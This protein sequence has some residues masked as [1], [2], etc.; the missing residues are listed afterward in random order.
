MNDFEVKSEDTKDDDLWNGLKAVGF[1]SA[2]ELD[3]VSDVNE[4]VSH[5]TSETFV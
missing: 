4:E 5:S 1:N 3:M 2:L